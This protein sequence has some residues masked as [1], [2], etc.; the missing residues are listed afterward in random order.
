M[1]NRSCFGALGC[2]SQGVLMMLLSP[3]PQLGT[4][5]NGP[6]AAGTLG[7]HEAFPMAGGWN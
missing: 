3:L 7:F 6:C 4:E 5:G 1:V 2:D